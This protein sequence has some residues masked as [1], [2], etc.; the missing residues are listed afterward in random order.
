MA[1]KDS[2][3]DDGFLENFMQKQ[4]E[5]VPMPESM[6]RLLKIIIGA[7]VVILV[8]IIA[9]VV[10][11]SADN[12]QADNVPI[13]RADTEPYKV[14]PEDRGGMPIPNRDSS[15]FET[16]EK[17]EP[18]KIE[19][20]LED[21]EEPMKKDEVFAADE[22]QS[23]PVPSEPTPP[24]ASSAQ[25]VAES[26]V[27]ATKPPVPKPE[28][29]PAKVIEDKKT[30]VIATLKQEA[31]TTEAV[32]KVETAKEKLAPKSSGTTYI[33]LAAVKSDDDAKKK[34]SQLQGKYSSLKSLSLR[35]KKADLGS[36]GVFYRVQAGP[37]SADMAAT[38]CSKIKSAGG[39]CLVVK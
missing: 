5:V 31:G 2:F 6:S 8:S 21:T 25:T 11:P 16:I 38:T 10:W 13:V 39:D 30:D 14:E 3:D 17:T 36:K 34:W 24:V 35:V 4:R 12:P 15:I 1:N 32:K 33:Q 29:E 9:W 23:D 7:G 19:N 22:G 37:M 20:L 27:E 18:R 28:A 26:K